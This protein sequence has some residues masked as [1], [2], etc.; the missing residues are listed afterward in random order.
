MMT[1]QITSRFIFDT[2]AGLSFLLSKDFVDDSTVFKK[3]RKFYPT[4]AE[5]LGG[6]RQMTFLLPKK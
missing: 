3:N 5:G 4:Q 1:G 6:K 2:G